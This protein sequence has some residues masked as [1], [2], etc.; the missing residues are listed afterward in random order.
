MGTR[1][2]KPLM[3]MLGEKHNDWVFMLRSMLKG[4][5]QH[6]LDEETYIIGDMYIRLNKYV[7]DPD[8]IMYGDEINTMFIY[9]T[10]RNCMNKYFNKKN[11]YLE[12]PVEPWRADR[13]D[14]E[15]NVEY[16]LNKVI[17]TDNIIEEV[18]SWH[19]FEARIFKI[20]SQ[21]KGSMRKLS[22][23]TKIS[24]STIFNSNKKSKELLKIMFQDEYN[25][26][27]D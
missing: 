9:I 5:N 26:L 11:K 6:T 4:K 18:D 12:V 15:Y 19:W 22:R 21:D 20:L 7:K 23:D 8:R 25:K 13:V 16:E 2:N 14:E 10:L 17:L 3:E 1:I 24:L 27:K